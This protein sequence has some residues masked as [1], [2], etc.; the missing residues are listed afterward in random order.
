MSLD[1]YLELE[2]ARGNILSGGGKKIKESSDEEDTYKARK[3]DEFV[4]ENPKGAGNRM[5]RG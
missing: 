1:E 2:M 4:E 3:W 5:N